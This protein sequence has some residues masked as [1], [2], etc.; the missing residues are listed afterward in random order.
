MKTCKHGHVYG[1]HD[2]YC[3]TCSSLRSAA[4][5]TRVDAN[6]NAPIYLELA[7]KPW[8]TEA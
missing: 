1:P 2:T 3:K 8:R 5:R 6:W 4:R 7:I